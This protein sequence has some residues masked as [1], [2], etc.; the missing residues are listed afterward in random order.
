MR[1]DFFRLA[2]FVFGAR[3]DCPSVVAGLSV[4]RSRALVQKVRPQVEERNR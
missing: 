2:V 1:A 4:V 3:G